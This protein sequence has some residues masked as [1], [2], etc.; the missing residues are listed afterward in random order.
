MLLAFYAFCHSCTGFCHSM[1]S[2]WIMSIKTSLSLVMSCEV[3]ERSFV[4]SSNSFSRRDCLVIRSSRNSEFC[5]V[6]LTGDKHCL[7]NHTS[8]SCSA[9]YSWYCDR[10]SSNIFE[11]WELRCLSACTSSSCSISHWLSCICHSV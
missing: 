3:D 2:C 7:S 8:L 4:L 10:V 9:M 1:H 5:K 6:R 11:S